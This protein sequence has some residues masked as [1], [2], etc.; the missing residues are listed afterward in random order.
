MAKH[1][2]I[3]FDE[4]EHQDIPGAYCP[5]P[6]P[7]H[8]KIVLGHGSGGKLTQDLIQNVFLPPLENPIL[9]I[10]DDAGVF[11]LNGSTRLAISTDSHVVY[12]LFFPGGDIGRL[13][14]CGTVN[15]ISMMGAV[16]IYMTAGFIIE[17]GLDIQ[18]ISQI[19]HSMQS[20]AQE[21]NIQVIAGDT[22]V[23][24]KGKADSIY[25]N[26]TG[27]GQ[28]TGDINISGKMAK[29]GDTIII[30]GTIGDHGIA[31]LAARGELGFETTVE[32]DIAPLNSLVADMLSSGANIHA[33]RDPTRGGLATSLNEICQQSGVGMLIHERKIPVSPQVMA[34][35]EML[36]FDPLYIA[37]EGKLVAIVAKEDAQSVLSAMRQNKYG[38][39][40][41]II[42]EVIEESQSRVLIKT[43][44]GTTRIV[45]VLAGEMLPRIC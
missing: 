42:G 26:T 41:E 21:A 1:S 27:I 40:A 31:V 43:P 28:I 23:V 19:V 33:L 39:E 6:L 5:L 25:I 10:G 8:E 36:G 35:C 18:V 44:I 29:P 17:E 37:N 14:V 20:A 2:E 34:A 16:P 9:S 15:D 7:H 12:P 3:S 22:K 11:L 4:K 38:R 13:A 45:D 30:S 24:Q 32:S